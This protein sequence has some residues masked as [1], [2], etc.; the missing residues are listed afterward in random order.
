MGTIASTLGHM[1]AL[2]ASMSEPVAYIP[3]G[4]ATGASGYSRQAFEDLSVVGILG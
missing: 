4:S 1:V 2:R 3:S